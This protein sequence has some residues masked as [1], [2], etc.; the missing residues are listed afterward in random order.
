MKRGHTLIVI[1]KIKIKATY[2]PEWLKLERLS[3]SSVDKDLEQ[4]K[5]VI[6]CWYKGKLVNFEKYYGIIY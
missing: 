1:R 2:T 6:H 4:L 5:P 3:S